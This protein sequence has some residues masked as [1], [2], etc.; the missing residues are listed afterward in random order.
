MDA[1]ICGTAIMNAERNRMGLCI[2][3]HM[4]THTHTTPCN[5][6][7]QPQLSR[8]PAQ[9]TMATRGAAGRVGIKEN[10]EGRVHKWE[11][12]WVSTKKG[13]QKEE[14]QMQL[15]KWIQTGTYLPTAGS[16]LRQIQDKGRSD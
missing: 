9:S 15:M 14:V 3:V 8:A 5:R 16:S 13:T 6:P 2:C 11:R 12:R 1:C 10:F 4:R 7:V